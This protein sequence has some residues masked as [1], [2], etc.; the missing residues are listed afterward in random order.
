MGIKAV[1]PAGVTDLTVHGLHQWD[2]GQ[3]LE[4]HDSTLPASIEVHFAHRGMDVAPVVLCSVA[5]GVATARIPD[6]C[7]KQT[8]PVVAWVYEANDASGQTIRTIIMPLVARARPENVAEGAAAYVDVSDTTAT[9]DEVL[10]GE[11][12]HKADGSVAVGT[13]VPGSGGGWALPTFDLVEAGMPTVPLTGETKDL[14]HTLAADICAALDQG[15]VKFIME[16]ETYGEVE[17]IMSKASIGGQ[18]YQCTHAIV[19]GTE[20][21]LIS[22]TIAG[23]YISACVSAL[24]GGG[25]GG[26]GAID[27]ANIPEVESIDN[28]TAASPSAVRYDGEIYL[29]VED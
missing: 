4:I 24:G 25:G 9:E 16:F 12:F 6:V 13:L 7:L 1:F 14:E 3:I 5:D 19:L 8:T 23:G 11:I 18:V 10:Q 17:L 26:G 21:K 15:P 20:T 27:L 28:P 29:L 22:L 2:R